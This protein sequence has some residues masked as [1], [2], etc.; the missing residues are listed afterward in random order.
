MLFS[1]LTFPSSP[2]FI[3]PVFLW[4][5]IWG[6]RWAFILAL[7]LFFLSAQINVLLKEFFQI[8]M[9]PSLG[10]GDTY[11][12]PSG[13]IQNTTVLWGIIAGAYKKPLLV[14]LI[15]LMMLLNSFAIYKLGYH[16]VIEIVGGAY[17]GLIIMAG[18]FLLL[19]LRN[20]NH[21]RP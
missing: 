12:F 15:T 17:I 14:I 8:P 16:T 6:K 4:G 2:Y 20:A 7:V 10:L 11:A 3:G 5:L 1:L 13:H 21:G 18:L 9:N 19:R